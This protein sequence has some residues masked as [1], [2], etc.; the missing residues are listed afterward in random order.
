MQKLYD[1][2]ENKCEDSMAKKKLNSKIKVVKQI[3]VE[4]QYLYVENAEI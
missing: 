2:F 4:N 3:F 1:L